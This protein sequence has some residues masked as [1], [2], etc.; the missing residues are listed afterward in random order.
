MNTLMSIL[1]NIPFLILCLY[2][3]S[4]FLISAY[5]SKLSKGS[6]SD[7]LLAG[8]KLT[9]PLIAV[10]VAGLA[11]G[12][13][14]TVGV[15]E[16][17][18]SG[19]LSAGW[20][21]GAWA[22]GALAMGL[23]A[24]GKYREL[25]VS[26]LPELFDRVF[27]KYSRLM[28]AAALLIVLMMIASLQYLAGGAILSTM[29]P[30]F[31]SFKAGMLVSAAV[32]IG[33]A[34]IGGLWSSG[35]SNIISVALIY[36]GIIIA[37]IVSLTKVGGFS[38]LSAQLP[39]GE[40]WLSFK[41]NLPLSILIG[42]FVV[43]ISQALSAQGTV[44][45][46]CSAKDSKTAK[47]GFIW[48]ALLIFPI[49][50]F[51]AVLG[52]VAR[53]LY[54]DI[55]PTVALP[56]V[57]LGLS[58]ILA[59]V[60]ISALW[61]ADV[62]TACTILMGA[63]TLLTQDIFKR[64]IKPNASEKTLSITSRLAVVLVG[65]FTLILAFQASNIV[66]TMMIS[67]SLTTAFTLVFLMVLFKPEWCRKSSAFWTTLVGIIGLIVW[68]FIPEVPVFF[69]HYLPFFDHVIYFEWLLCLLTFF[70]VPLFDKRRISLGKTQSVIETSSEETVAIQPA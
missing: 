61:A 31:F 63:S 3:G 22:G 40:H 21:N 54:P 9:T 70:A 33:I 15:A 45:I 2:I 39:V 10:S 48:G 25:N 16:S 8:R 53:V 66:K 27:G 23:V 57:I 43:M 17:A 37:T 49:G 1:S 6:T 65:L 7:F 56:Q 69:K 59:G 11:V 5:A 18:Y 14:S 58:P 44:Q 19:G 12:A 34:L 29:L 52:M 24:A 60:I 42:W 62:S 46:A 26:S 13:A 35:L 68:Q 51:C 50:F 30:E 67:L 28:S 41:G 64:F 55:I 47:R 38:G 32:F 4:L 36:V 20:Y